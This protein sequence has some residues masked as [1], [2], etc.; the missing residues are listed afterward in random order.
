MKK[1]DSIGAMLLVSSSIMFDSTAQSN[2][3]V[4]ADSQI[5]VLADTGSATTS[6]TVNQA[7]RTNAEKSKTNEGTFYA[8]RLFWSATDHELYFKG[9]V[10]AHMN[11]QDFIV[12]GSVN[13]L[14][15]VYLLIINDE[16]AAIDSTIK[17]S[18]RQYRLI[19]LSD[20]EAAQKYGEKGTFTAETPSRKEPQRFFNV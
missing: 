3:A 17:L 13:F 5:I 15:P 6:V 14:G 4:H 11:D 19:R 18:K 2:Q 7:V 8:S 12:D 1:L 9:E 10:V 16:Q 20:K